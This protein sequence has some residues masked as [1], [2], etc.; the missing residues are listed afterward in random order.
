MAAHND[1]ERQKQ[2]DEL[3]SSAP[4]RSRLVDFSRGWC[5]T[6]AVLRSVSFCL[7]IVVIILI[8]VFATDLYYWVVVSPA[9]AVATSWDGAELITALV[10]RKVGRGIAPSAHVALD[11]LICILATGCSI[12]LGVG[13]FVYRD[14][15]ALNVYHYH[16]LNDLGAMIVRIVCIV[17]LLIVA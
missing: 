9:V 13:D 4:E 3:S 1:H 15:P 16:V 6:K 8:A 5:V 14:N 10:R 11:L 12:V 2:A 17:L 7:S